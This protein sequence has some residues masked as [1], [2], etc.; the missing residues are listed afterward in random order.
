M[1]SNP[2]NRGKKPTSRK[3]SAKQRARKKRNRVI[4]FTVEILVLL[5]ML[6]VLYFVTKGEKSTKIAIKE[7]NIVINEKVEESVV[8]K[9]YRNIALF[10]L[11]SRD[12]S[13]GKGNRSD[14][15]LIASINMDTYDVKLMSVYRD[16]YLN[17]GN[18]KYGKCNAAYAKGGPEQAIN[19]LNMNL[20]MNIT[21][22]VTVGFTGM[23]ETIDALGGIEIDVTDAEIQH[24]NSYQICMSE[25]LKKDY[26]PVESPGLQLL[27]GMQATAYCR[28][29][30]TRG[31][32][33]KR[34]ERQR[35][36]LMKIVEKAKKAD[37]ATL[38]KIVDS[39]MP[40]ISTSLDVSEI[41]S[42]LGEATKYN[43]VA[44][45]GFPFEDSRT[46][47]NVGSAGSSVIPL[48][49][50]KN[51]VSL[52]KFFFDEEYTPS[53]DVKRYSEKVAS[54]TGAYIGK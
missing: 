31:D 28:I 40:N 37:V 12:K 23:I 22:Y 6:G 53:D 54:D 5:I 51:V 8:M 52:H 11:D 32:D 50:E 24:L 4:L 17:L 45:D 10:G 19:M 33:F 9:G 38:T 26:T 46:T 16:T 42:V 1:A 7:E 36:V 34:A 41:L 13:L 44:N 3:M 25:E 21:D 29:R 20:D 35:N 43:I 49:L 27:D 2:K 15:I 48:D 18:D 39:V 47:G 14:T 30:Y